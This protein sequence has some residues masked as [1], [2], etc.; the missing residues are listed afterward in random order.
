[1]L[2]WVPTF[3]IYRE[4]IILYIS[5]I[6]FSL[7]CFKDLFVSLSI[8]SNYYTVFHNIYLLYFMSA[9]PFVDAHIYFN[10]PT[11]IDNTM[12]NTPVDLYDV[13]FE[14]YIQ[15]CDFWIIG[16]LR[17]YFMERLPGGVP[18]SCKGLYSCKQFMRASMSLYPHRTNR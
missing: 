7:L 9:L 12:I 5:L 8:A 14:I 11:T 13:F 1:M 3:S 10:F 2:F 6:F 16:Y 4:D 15:E 17:T 18:T